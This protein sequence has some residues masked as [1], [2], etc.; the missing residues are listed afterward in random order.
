M[1]D[2]PV[3][4]FQYNPLMSAK[5]SV[6]RLSV[7]SNTRVALF[8]SS[9]SKCLSDV[10]GYFLGRIENPLNPGF[11]PVFLKPSINKPWSHLIYFK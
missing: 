9:C 4:T 5:Q 6:D 8:L 3:D 10:V 11:S 1:T 7:I 2:C